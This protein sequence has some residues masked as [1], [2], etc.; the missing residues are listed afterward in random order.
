M[1]M[2]VSI[3][4]QGM[5]FWIDDLSLVCPENTITPRKRRVWL[6]V[7]N[8]LANA[9]SNVITVVPVYSRSETRNPSQVFFKNGDRDCVICCDNVVS[10]PKDKVVA[11]DYMGIISS[12]LWE[13]V[14]NA[15]MS[16]FRDIHNEN[17]GTVVTD[18]TT[19]LL[20]DKAFM[21]GIVKAVITTN[22]T[23]IKTNTS[24]TKT[25]KTKYNRNATD[26]KHMDIDTAR[27]FYLDT[28]DGDI[29]KANAMYGI[30]GKILNK[31]HLSKKRYSIKKRLIAHGL[32]T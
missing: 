6:V 5:L 29:D 4:K 32:L 27:N 16:Q 24:D 15:L 28:V 26:I 10:I 7:S 17:P 12:N 3:I 19:Q 8:D 30:Y 25:T 2:N 1:C 23:T 9:T 13:K 22:T 18:I 20:N 14:H 31:S 11:K 21:N